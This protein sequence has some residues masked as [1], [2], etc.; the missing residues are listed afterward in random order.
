LPLMMAS[1]APP[2]IYPSPTGE[3][4]EPV[5]RQPLIL[6]SAGPSSDPSIG[7]TRANSVSLLKIEDELSLTYKQYLMVR[8]IWNRACICVQSTYTSTKDT[9]KSGTN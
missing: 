2:T 4:S 8:L 1:S 9:T 7:P 5:T 3:L 6:P